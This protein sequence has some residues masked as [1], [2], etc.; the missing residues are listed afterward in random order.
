MGQK[1]GRT[2]IEMEQQYIA[3]L[4]NVIFRFSP[5]KVFRFHCPLVAETDDVF[6]LHDFG[7][8][9]TFDHIGMDCPC[10]FEC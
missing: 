9:E 4:N 1:I 6:R 3:V 7:T 8:D 2:L 10:G 5:D